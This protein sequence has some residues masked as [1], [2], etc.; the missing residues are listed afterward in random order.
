MCGT[1]SASKSTCTVRC[2]RTRIDKFLIVITPSSR[3]GPG[4]DVY[5]L[6]TLL[7]P[8]PPSLTELCDSLTHQRLA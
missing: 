2:R 1:Q 8:A 7:S 3:H 5:H 6:L 4:P